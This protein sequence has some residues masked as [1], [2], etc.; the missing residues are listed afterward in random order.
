MPYFKQVNI[1]LSSFNVE[2][3]SDGET[4]RFTSSKRVSLI[5]YGIKPEY[6]EALL[7]K[8]PESLRGIAHV[9]VTRITGPGLAVPHVDHGWMSKINFYVSGA[10][11]KTT[12]HEL[13]NDQPDAI[14][15][16][17]KERAN[18]FHMK[19][20][21]DVG[22]F[23]ASNGEAYALD[24]SKIHSVMMKSRETRVMIA[25]AFKTLPLDELVQSL[26]SP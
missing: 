12:F 22:S 26:E 19:D 11:G 4:E 6:H 9:C 24:V 8:L 10:G 7:K 2:T 18:I 20:L 13:A 1:D 21:V 25:F 15:Y 23:S 16:E 5:Y 14:T 3:I 17:G